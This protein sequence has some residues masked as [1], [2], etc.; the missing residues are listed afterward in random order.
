[1]S[2]D[3]KTGHSF[4]E[5][6]GHS[7]TVRQKYNGNNYYRKEPKSCA[8]CKSKVW[9]QPRVYAGKYISG[10]MAKRFKPTGRAAAKLK[11]DPE[12][13][14]WDSIAGDDGLSPNEKIDA[15]LATLS[16]EERLAAKRQLYLYRL[17]AM[18][19]ELGIK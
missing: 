18:L 14:E 9:N 12:Q 1:M 2:Y 11:C 19:E 7:W 17:A 5:R 3:S 6:C 4:C 13:A 16:P 10:T 15:I 8:K